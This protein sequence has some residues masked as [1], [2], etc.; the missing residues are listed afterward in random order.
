MSSLYNID[1]LKHL[2]SKYGLIPSKKYGQ[3]FVINEEPIEKMLE[4][5][6]IKPDGVVVEVGPGF[7]VLTL[8]SPFD[9]FATP[10]D[11]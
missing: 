10:Q 2:C 1:Y 3:N 11:F 4:A 9:N 5:A 8:G 6:E 7:G